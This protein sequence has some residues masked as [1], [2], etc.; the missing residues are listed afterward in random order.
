MEIPAHAPTTS[1][2]P[3]FIP[4]TNVFGEDI[5]YMSLPDGSAKMRDSI[6]DSMISTAPAESR[7]AITAK[8]SF[9]VQKAIVLTLRRGSKKYYIVDIPAHRLTIKVTP[10]F[11][12]ITHV[13]REDISYMS[14]LDASAKMRD[15]KCDR[16]V[17]TVA[18]EI[19]NT[20][21]AM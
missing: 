9:K 18:T 4:I 1:V 12:A 7:N 21:T 2:T 10:C 6:C 8:K 11:P 13:F 14:S 15:S 5:S 19:M 20:S 3:F 17:F 16:K